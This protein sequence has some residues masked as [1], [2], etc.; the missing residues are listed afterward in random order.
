[1]IL[2]GCL[3]LSEFS[4]AGF[5]SE[6]DALFE[7]AAEPVEGAA[8]EESLFEEAGEPVEGAAAEESSFEGDD[9]FSDVLAA[10]NEVWTEDEWTE[11]DLFS[12][13]EASSAADADTEDFELPDDLFFEEEAGAESVM[14]LGEAETDWALA[15]PDEE[16]ETETVTETADEVIS[17]LSDGEEEP[18]TSLAQLEGD[19]SEEEPYH[20]SDESHLQLLSDLAME[21]TLYG[22]FVLDQDIEVTK[23]LF[24]IGQTAAKA[25]AGHFD[26]QNH[27][28][29]GLLIADGTGMTGLFGYNKGEIRNLFVEGNYA[30]T[31]ITGMLAGTNNGTIVNCHAAGSVSS[32]ANHGG[33]IGEN[34]SGGSIERCTVDAAITGSGHAGGFA[35]YNDGLIRY[36]GA[37]GNVTGSTGLAGGFCGYMRNS[38]RIENCYAQGDVKNNATNAGF[39]GSV[40][41]SSAVRYCYASGNAG[42]NAGAGLIAGEYYGGSWQFSYFNS[43][44]TYNR[45]GIPATKAQLKQRSTFTGWD[46]DHVWSL[47]GEAGTTDG[48]GTENGGVS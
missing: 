6:G 18:L 9:V 41:H 31:G 23:L 24:P 10:E 15:I 11:E 37:T 5:A 38:G 47:P 30:G 27:T 42:N 44:N 32:S 45:W 48:T 39:L 4:S 3:V 12:D 21:N 26:G 16:E 2:A 40:G 8:A 7:E 19:G 22:Y 35:G 34:L 20:I 28:I 36:C 46:F 1:M 17:E 13:G 29:S 14:E 43:A 33:L 25:F